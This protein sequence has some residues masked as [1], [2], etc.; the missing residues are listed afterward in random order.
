MS[1]PI[2]IGGGH[3]A[4]TGTYVSVAYDLL[5]DRFIHIES[6]IGTDKDGAE[7]KSLQAVLEWVLNSRPG[8]D[9]EIVSGSELCAHAFGLLYLSDPNAPSY[10]QHAHL[11]T[12]IR[13]L[14]YMIPAPYGLVRLRYLD[15]LTVR[16]GISVNDFAGVIGVQNKVHELLSRVPEPVL[17]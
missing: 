6:G 17:A 10:Q 13:R 9:I 16:R 2:Y 14:K 4:Q 5:P 11:I 1:R 15:E 3:E 8:T 7:L 12:G